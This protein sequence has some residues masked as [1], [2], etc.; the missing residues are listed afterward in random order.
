[1]GWGQRAF[2]SNLDKIDAMELNLVEEETLFIPESQLPSKYLEHIEKTYPTYFSMGMERSR[3]EW[4]YFLRSKGYRA[5]PLS[6]SV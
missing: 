2:N 4:V 6:G 3:G 5:L 1:M